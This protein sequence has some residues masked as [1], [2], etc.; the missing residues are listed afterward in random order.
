MLVKTN[1][2]NKEGKAIYKNALTGEEN[3]LALHKV[4]PSQRAEKRGSVSQK[5][6]TNRKSTKGRKIYY[7]KKIK[8]VPQQIPDR[9]AF[10][11]GKLKKFP[12]HTKMIQKNVTIKHIQETSAAIRRKLLMMDTLDRIEVNKSKWHKA[13][14]EYQRKEVG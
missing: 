1:R 4:Y 3:I 2:F 9:I 7:T 10:V 8:E 13:H 12:A 14:P 6:Q 11:K 5:V